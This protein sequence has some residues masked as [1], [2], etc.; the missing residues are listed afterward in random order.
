VQSRANW[1]VAGTALGL[2]GFAGALRADEVKVALKD[3]PEGI[4]AAV[5]KRFPDAELTE[6]AK[7]TE[8]GKVT[9]EV[10]IKEKGS[11]IDVML[12]SEGAITKIEKSIPVKDLP[13]KITAA[14]EAKHAKAEIKSA[15][16]V[17]DVAKDG[18]EKLS[19]YEVVVVTAEKKKLEVEITP[20]G[21]I[22][23]AEPKEDEKEEKEEK[24]K[25]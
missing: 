1:I 5:K 22:K 17:I 4:S 7:E 15:E 18:K 12:S 9:F 14:V 2:L 24:K 6:A 23:A 11:K 8:K 19:Y 3:L 20:D 25:G 16:E 13:E 21:K 10:S